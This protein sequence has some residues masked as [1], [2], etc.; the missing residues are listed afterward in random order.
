MP[1]CL[2]QPHPTP[3]D[4]PTC[5]YIQTWSSPQEIV[6]QRICEG[7][8]WRGE[9]ARVLTNFQVTAFRGGGWR[10][11]CRIGRRRPPADSTLRP[12][13]PAAAGGHPCCAVRGGHRR[14][15]LPVPLRRVALPR[16]PAGTLLRW[17]HHRTQNVIPIRLAPV[18]CV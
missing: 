3:S 10:T 13:R 5:L 11:L 1:H 16:H 8:Q 15:P 7:A 14:V 18:C 4:P 2:A 17:T 6:I 9:V 12:E